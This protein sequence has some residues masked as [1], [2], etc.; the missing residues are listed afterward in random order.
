[1]PAFVGDLFLDRPEPWT[2]LCV[3]RPQFRAQRFAPR[4]LTF[5]ITVGDI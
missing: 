1:M 2:S 4:R 3:I 5:S